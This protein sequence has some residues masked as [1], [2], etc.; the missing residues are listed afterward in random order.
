MF[1]ARNCTF[2]LAEDLMHLNE[3]ATVQVRDL[4]FPEL[5]S[6]T[7]KLGT[8]NVERDCELSRSEAC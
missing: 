6:C 2:V 8:D 3:M 7:D 1:F 4:R 5:S